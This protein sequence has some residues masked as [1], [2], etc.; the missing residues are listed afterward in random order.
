MA[1]ATD[2]KAIHVSTLKRANIIF[3]ARVP[4]LKNAGLTTLRES[5]VNEAGPT[6]SD[7]LLNPI[8]SQPNQSEMDY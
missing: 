4:A 2:A 7:A 3:A 8:S 6:Q 1:L 5:L